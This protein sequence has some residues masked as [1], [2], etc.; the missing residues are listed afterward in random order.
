MIEYNDG[1]HL[2]GTGLWF[3]AHK[4]TELTFISSADIERFTAPE[5]T[6]AT[7]E[8]IKL[9]EK[10]ARSSLLLSCP[11]RRPFT[12]GNLQVELIPSG[13]MLGSAQM[14][15]DKGN[16]KIIYSGDINFLKTPTAEQLSIKECNVLV[17]KCGY[18][19]EEKKQPD[20]KESIENLIKFIEGAFSSDTTP[21]VITNPIGIGQD[22]I[23]TLGHRGYKLS[24]HS[25]IHR[26][27]KVYEY[28]G[29][30]FGDYKLLKSANSDDRIILLPNS[31]IGSEYLK[32]IENCRIA[33]ITEEGVDADTIS[34][35]TEEYIKFT[36]RAGSTDLLKY[37]DK[38]KPDKLYLIDKSAQDF[39]KIL[40]KKGYDA[41][42]LEKPT[43][44]N[45]L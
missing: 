35:E 10:K 22:I 16:L 14:V 39:A 29:I 27:T 23:N 25:S 32:N 38:V 5:K 21:V 28:Y 33:D 9:L 20:F 1:I 3:D 7:P 2:I 31:Q 6:I 8:T 12:L 44:L 43:Q 24:L 15:I 30:S 4:K 19:A 42:V 26:I 34:L 40:E 37:V 13:H 36:T 45:L 11:Y 17:L 41:I 18:G